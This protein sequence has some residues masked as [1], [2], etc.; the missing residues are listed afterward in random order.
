MWVWLISKWTKTNKVHPMILSHIIK[1]VPRFMTLDAIRK[2]IAQYPQTPTLYNIYI[3]NATFDIRHFI[4]SRYYICLSFHWQPWKKHLVPRRLRLIKNEME[5]LCQKAFR[6]AYRV[7]E[8]LYK[9]TLHYKFAY[10]NRL[11]YVL[12]RHWVLCGIYLKLKNIYA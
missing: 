3:R 6:A 1:K 7:D 11:V 12:L 4:I 8:A 2:R 5:C 10:K 9:N